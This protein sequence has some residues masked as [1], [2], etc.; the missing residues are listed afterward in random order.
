MTAIVLTK[1]DIENYLSV[2]QQE[3]LSDIL[4]TI[5]TGRKNDLLEKSKLA[6]E[7]ILKGGKECG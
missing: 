4:L 7:V 6:L 2:E 3:N 5:E 1:E